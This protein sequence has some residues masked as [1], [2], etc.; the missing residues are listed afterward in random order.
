MKTL[1]FVFALALGQWALAGELDQELL[2]DDVRGVMDDLNV[3][4]C[5]RWNNATQAKEIVVYLTA[6]L[7]SWDDANQTGLANS[8]KASPEAA[9]GMARHIQEVQ[10]HLQALLA[11]RDAIAQQL[12]MDK[13]A[14]ERMYRFNTLTSDEVLMF[15]N[16]TGNYAGQPN[17][18]SKLFAIRDH[19]QALHLIDLELR[20]LN[21]EIPEMARDAE[22]D[23]GKPVE[24][25]E[26]RNLA[27]YISF[28][29][30]L[31]N[32]RARIAD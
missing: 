2:P 25:L 30:A 8:R 14:V 3:N 17:Y 12:G 24:D 4:V 27:R 18:F 6:A 1:V 20:E 11:C 13:T 9:A 28:R 16:L 32:A 23:A 19:R 29:K 5:P 21:Y 15:N 7:H 26:R 22:R 31:V 10:P